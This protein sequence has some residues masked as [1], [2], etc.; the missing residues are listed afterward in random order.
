V[1]SAN[2]NYAKVAGRAPDL[3]GRGFNADSFKFLMKATLFALRLNELLELFADKS[4]SFRP[5]LKMSGT[6]KR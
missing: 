1:E 6:S 4:I 3:T 5:H 2:G